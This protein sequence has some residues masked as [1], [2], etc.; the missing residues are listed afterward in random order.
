MMQAK[1]SIFLVPHTIH[2]YCSVL[3]VHCAAPSLN[4]KPS[5]AI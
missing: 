4:Q 5:Q 2:V 1:C 3:S